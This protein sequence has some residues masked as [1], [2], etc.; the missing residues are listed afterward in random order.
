[1][2]NFEIIKTVLFIILVII[3]IYI[4]EQIWQWLVK[5]VKFF[6]W[7]NKTEYEESVEKLNLPK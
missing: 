2:D 1:M 5:N 7:L 6:K 3:A 4:G